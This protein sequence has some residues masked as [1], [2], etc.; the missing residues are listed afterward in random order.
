MRLPTP[1]PKLRVSEDV[2]QDKSTQEVSHETTK[3]TNEEEPRS[4]IDRIK[5]MGGRKMRLP[6]PGAK[7]MDLKS[8]KRL[9]TPKVAVKDDEVAASQIDEETPPKQEEKQEELPLQQE[10][11]VKS[12][13]IRT[14]PSRCAATA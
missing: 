2:V 8:K 14:L 7:K 12:P 5:A 11:E 13:P 3:T 9:P 6:T 10:E 1:K 4:A